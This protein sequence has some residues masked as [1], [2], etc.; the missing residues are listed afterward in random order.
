MKKVLKKIRLFCS[1]IYGKLLYVLVNPK[2]KR[3]LFTSFNGKY[4]DSPK[5]LSESIHKLD[6]KIEIVWLLDNKNMNNAP[7][8]VKRVNISNYFKRVWHQAR[9]K[10]IIDNVYGG[11]EASLLGTTK[12]DKRKFRFFS[13]INR[14]KKQKVYTT[15][16]GTPL[17]RMGRDQIGNNVYDFSCP[18]TTM[19]LGN[20]FTL[21]IMK[22]LTFDKTKMQL[23]GCPRNDV[24]FTRGEEKVFRN[25]LN[26][27]TD[28]KIA[29][30]APTF[31]SDGQDSQE[32][33]VERSGINQLEEIDFDRLFETLKDK[34]GG[35]WVL[36]CRFHY[37]VEK[38]VDWQNLSKKYSGRVINGN[39][40]DD[41]S[42][43]L[44]ASDLLITDASSSMFDYIHTGKP[45][46]LYF[47]DYDNY[48][49][50]ER[51]FYLDIE[52]LPFSCSTD[53][54]G[55]LDDIAKFDSDRYL[56][57]AEKLKEELGYVDNN[58]SS[59]E[60]AKFILEEMKNN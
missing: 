2:K 38:M 60:I 53:F 48:K 40:F 55:L 9:A 22:R 15:W 11:R 49:N 44:V 56:S 18:N 50:N 1:L 4:S 6:E 37:H 46:F 36:V 3:I 19:I 25:K 8:Y 52:D 10:V 43:Y 57:C 54:N 21:D 13:F 34:F 35:E 29:I 24:L 5:Y 30:F 23:L 45:C 42:E 31:R 26:L 58:N 39:E 12:K 14:N 41:M 51:G 59:N 27:P 16:H 17:K 7:D 20:K 33:N 47:P 32:K 28:K